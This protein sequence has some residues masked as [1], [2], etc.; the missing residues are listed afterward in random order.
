M[1]MQ[2]RFRVFLETS[3]GMFHHIIISATPCLDACDLADAIFPTSHWVPR[4]KPQSICLQLIGKY[5]ALWLTIP[6]HSDIHD[7]F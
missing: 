6:E 7:L 4:G 5:A 3:F 2:I 1:Q